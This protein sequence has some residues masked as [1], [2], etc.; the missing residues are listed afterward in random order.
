MRFILVAFALGVGAAQAQLVDV[1]GPPFSIANVLTTTVVA[2]PACTAATSGLVYRVTDALLPTVLGTVA[3]GGAVSTLV[4]CA[5]TL[6][7][8][9]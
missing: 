8:A 3:G 4:H 5:G 1:S 2:L 6:W 7:V 9:G